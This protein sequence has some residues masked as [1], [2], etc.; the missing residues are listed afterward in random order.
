MD[1][2]FQTQT[3]FNFLKYTMTGEVGQLL[4]N[5]SEGVDSAVF[6]RTTFVTCTVSLPNFDWVRKCQV[7][8]IH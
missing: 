7:L 5:R 8:G 4:C 1:A 2:S 6:Y 3:F